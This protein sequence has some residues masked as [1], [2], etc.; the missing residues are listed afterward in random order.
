MLLGGDEPHE[1][2]FVVDVDS[3]WFA[4]PGRA[5]DARYEVCT[6]LERKGKAIVARSS[7]GAVV[8][9][10]VGIPTSVVAPSHGV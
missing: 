2:G 4:T 8:K 7:M 1:R 10:C 9:T 3:L 6:P 5:W